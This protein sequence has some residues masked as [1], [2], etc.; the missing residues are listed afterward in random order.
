MDTI[1]NFCTISKYLSCDTKLFDQLNKYLFATGAIFCKHV[2]LFC[3]TLNIF[4][5]HES[6]SGC[7][8]F[9]V[10]TTYF[11]AAHIILLRNVNFYA[12]YIFFVDTTV[13]CAI[14]DFFVLPNVSINNICVKRN[15]S[16]AIKKI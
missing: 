3:A 9:F 10:A 1:F 15:R 11:F 5:Q 2:F 7:H 4:S 8:I 13:F 12:K 6:F 16:V 14:Q